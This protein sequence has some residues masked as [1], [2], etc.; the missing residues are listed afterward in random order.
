MTGFR[1]CFASR[2]FVF[3]SFKNR[4]IYYDTTNSDGLFA[5]CRYSDGAD[6]VFPLLQLEYFPYRIFLYGSGC[7]RDV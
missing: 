7:S 5:D 2:V 3:F 4:G 6:D 1:E